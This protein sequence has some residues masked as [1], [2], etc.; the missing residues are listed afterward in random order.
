MRGIIGVGGHVPHRRLD[1]SEVAAFFGKGG[2]RGQRAVASYDEDTTTMGAA[3]ARRA[4]A[5]APGVSP[6]SLWFSTSTPAY[7]EKTNATTIHASLRLGPSVDALDFGGALRSGAGALRTALTAGGPTLVV[8]ADQRDGLATSSDE[9]AGG[10]GAAAILVGDAADGP[11]IAEY[12]GCGIATDEFLERWRVPGAAR[13]RSW[14]ERFGEVTYGPL[15]T[16]AWEAALAATGLGVD[17]IDRLAVAGTHARAVSR[18][19]RRLGVADDRRIDD[20]SGTVGNLGTAHPLAVLTA[21]LETASPGETIALMTLADGVEVMVLRTTDAIA[22]FAPARSIAEQI[23]TGGSISYAQ[24]LS[25]RGLVAVEPPNRPLPNRPS[26]AASHR[27]DDWKFGFVGSRD[28]STGMIHLPPARVSE[29]GGAVDDMEPVPMAETPGTVVSF[30]ID[31]LVYSPSPPVVFA[32]VDFDGGGRAPLEL[33]DCGPDE[34]EIGLR[35]E[36]TFRRLFTADEIH[37]YF[38]KVQPVRSSE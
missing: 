5:S 13:S 1:R 20:L 31:K 11:V 36:P 2:G 15:M 10:D 3:A 33:A 28:R 32:V 4:L 17:D 9:V 37:N 27:R 14:E 18:N 12:L 21:A 6:A 25:W 26:A 30:T 22:D 29:K 38:W 35:V 16:D 24:F 19:A 23:A 7:L 34:V 8:A